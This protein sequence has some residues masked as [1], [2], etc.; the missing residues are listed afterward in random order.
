MQ[1][2]GINAVSRGARV[3]NDGAQL[4]TSLLVLWEV[5]IAA[6]RW[7]RSRANTCYHTHTLPQPWLGKVG[8]HYGE[9]WRTVVCPLPKCSSYLSDATQSCLGELLKPPITKSLE[10][11]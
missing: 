2:F 3:P 6:S 9:Y 10:Q 7:T 11:F 1:L 4:E 8:S 5:V